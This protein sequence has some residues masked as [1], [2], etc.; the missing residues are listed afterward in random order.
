MAY[1]FLIIP[2][3]KSHTQG[4]GLNSLLN[5]VFRRVYAT[6]DRRI[7]HLVHVCFHH[8]KYLTFY[9]LT[10]LYQVTILLI[11]SGQTKTSRHDN[12]MFPGLLIKGSLMGYKNHCH[13]LRF[14]QMW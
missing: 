5:K 1:T 2:I 4:N 14:Y 12:I 3:P 11:K 7:Y 13:A 10:P 6:D 8:H 9:T